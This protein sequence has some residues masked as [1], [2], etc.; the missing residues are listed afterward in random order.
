MPQIQNC[1][2]LTQNNT[3]CWS[4][5]GHSVRKDVF[6][7][8]C[9]FFFIQRPRENICVQHIWGWVIYKK[10]MVC[11]CSEIIFKHA[12]IIW[13]QL[14]LVEWENDW[15]KILQVYIDAPLHFRNF[16]RLNFIYSQT[17]HSPCPLAA[18]KFLRETDTGTQTITLQGTEYYD[19]DV[20]MCVY[21]PWEAKVWTFHSD[22]ERIRKEHRTSRGQRMLDVKS[23]YS[24][25]AS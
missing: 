5:T 3:E 18:D 14:N 9:G 17:K 8:L 20:C 10:K 6:A 12:V 13:H 25:W 23:K 16:M 11:N 15:P 7:T 1:L 21:F 19:K 2:F 22:Q 24:D 4:Q